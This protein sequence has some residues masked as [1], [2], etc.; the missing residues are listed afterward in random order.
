MDT[1]PTPHRFTRVEFS[2]MGEAGLFTEERVELLDG[3]IMTMPPQSPLHAGT[4]S[5]L[6]TEVVLLLKTDF[7]VRTRLPIALDT[8][9]ELEPDL[10]VCQFNP[11]DYEN[12]LPTANDVLLVIEVADASL[13]YDRSRKGAVYAG[14]GIPEY[15]IVNLVDHRIEVF[16]DPDPAA[17]RYR[18]ERIVRVGET[19]TL[20]GGINLAVSDVL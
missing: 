2:R 15:W 6:T 18:Q 12:D 8:W 4:T 11:N 16:S 20:P 14:S 9:N 3:A 13:D 7:T 19:L 10:A 5:I 17:Q 1:G